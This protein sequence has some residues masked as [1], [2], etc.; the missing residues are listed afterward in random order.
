M[1]QR[2]GTIASLKLIRWMFH[3]RKPLDFMEITNCDTLYV[4]TA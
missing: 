4:I 1:L 3:R 2:C